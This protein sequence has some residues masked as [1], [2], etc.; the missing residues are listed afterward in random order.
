MAGVS[1]A[2]Y[3]AAVDDLRRIEYPMLQDEIYLDHAGSTPCP[4]SLMDAF[5][6]D[7]TSHLYGNPHSASSSSQLSATRIDDIRLRL[8]SFFKADPRDFDLVFVANATA[9][10][11]LVVEAMRSLPSGYAYA[12]HQACHTSLVGARED[13]TSSTCL[14]DDRVYSWLQG[15][16]P[17]PCQSPVPSARLFS[18]TAQSH[19]DGQRFPLCWPKQLQAQ[20]TRDSP[21]LYTLVDAASLSATSQLDLGSPEFAA[22][23]VVLSLYKIFGF[24]DLGALI[25]RRSAESVF[26]HRRY[27]GGG[28]VDMVVCG[29][30]EWH[31][32][33]THGLHERLE[34]GTLP[35]HSIIA[36]DAALQVHQKL[37]SSM[38]RVSAHTSYLT[39]RLRNGLSSIRHENGR[40]VCVIYANKAPREPCQVQTGPIVSFNLVDSLGG[41]VSLTEFEK[42][43]MLH[44]IHIR[45]GGLCCPG[46][47]S[48]ALGLEPWE[49][50]RNLSA[51]FR[52]GADNDLIPGKP[53]GVIRASLGAMS[54]NSDVEKFVDF[55]KEFFV[56]SIK[57]DEPVEARSSAISH[58]RVKSL[59]IYPIK[60]C[61]GFA[62]PPSCPWAVRTEGLVW[63]REWC[64]VHRGSGQ[65]LSQKRYPNMALLQPTLDL[66]LGNLHVQ[67]S[68]PGAKAS[69]ADHVDIPLSI[70]P[71]L[72]SG[73][74]QQ[75]WS[76]VC[77]EDVSA[78][79]YKSDKINDFFSNALG[80]PCVLA[81]FPPGGRGSGSRSCKAR[82]Q[83]HQQ[84]IQHSRVPGCFPQI[85]SPPDSD[86]EQQQDGKILLS[87]ES[88]ILLIYSSSVDSLNDE[89]EARG[90]KR[91]SDAVFRANI[92]VEGTSRGGSQ[93]AYSE[94]GW[95]H[96]RIG[97]QDF[98]MLGACR[99]CQMVCVD[100]TTAERRQEPFAT[101]A[102]TRRFDGKVYFGAHMCHDIADH[103]EDKCLSGT[104]TIHVGQA[105]TVYR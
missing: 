103:G 24:P 64:L 16:D 73:T 30:D 98:R 19:M 11:K 50:R 42:L 82:I 84:L 89:I 92:V 74:F 12:Y 57:Q 104:R 3:N 23:F 5:A 97:N 44:K 46:G 91:V 102:K 52:C 85:P 105:V 78:Q 35:F 63:D 93:P 31:A 58:L 45:T 22:D 101:L 25:V 61:G 67:Y 95:S 54:S 69:I 1:P 10:V 94:D 28:T 37:F 77:G 32:R 41:W 68:K 80:V 55:V 38:Q 76:R 8:L 56:E 100:Q 90:G 9:G 18:F 87:N 13:A 59:T 6:A 40:P 15:Q 86:S 51:G 39:Q 33:K 71:S 48:A 62:I 7:M 88:P 60:S 17:F 83:K 72:F 21:R 36:V 4:K 75:T 14:D 2:A 47:I 27:F 49:L 81:R 96:I 53:S 34:D 20:A 43:A 99:R 70:D 65:A 29:E 26:D 66:K 79:A